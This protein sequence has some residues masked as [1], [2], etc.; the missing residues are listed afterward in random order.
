MLT[1]D[2][3]QGAPAELEKLFLKLE[4]EVI[5]DICRRIE[6]VGGLSDTA[7][8]QII[9]LREMGAGTEYIKKKIA[10]YSKLAD[11][12]IDRLFLML[13]RPPMNF[14]LKFTTRQTRN[15][16]PMSTMISFSRR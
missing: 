8:H 7:E 14:I 3:L 11:E 1:P 13:P 15:I 6:K 2:Y 5:R 16:H 12:E 9:R 10:E 4:E